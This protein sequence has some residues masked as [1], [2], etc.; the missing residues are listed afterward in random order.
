MRRRGMTFRKGSK[1]LSMNR[2][3]CRQ[4]LDCGD[5]V[6]EVTALTLAALKI[7]KLAADRATVTQSGDC[8]D[9]VAAV[10]DALAATRFALGSWSQCVRKNEWRLSMNRNSG[11]RPSGRSSPG[12]STPV[13]R[14]RDPSNRR[15]V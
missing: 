10:Q 11:A 13:D 1:K 3:I 2:R 15:G 5:G 9:S 4:V 12:I 14:W 7:T 6:R 8:E